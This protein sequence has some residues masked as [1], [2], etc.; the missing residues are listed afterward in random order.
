MD[1]GLLLLEICMVGFCAIL[2][3]LGKRD[4]N[5][6][7]AQQRAATIN[8]SKQLEAT[9]LGLI[10]VLE[11]KSQQIEARIQKRYEELTALEQKVN[12][13]LT[14]SRGSVPEV[15]ASSAQLDMNPLPVRNGFG[16]NWRTRG[17]TGSGDEMSPIS[18]AV[19]LVD[20]GANL[21]TAARIVGM[22][23]LEVETAI[24]ARLLRRNRTAFENGLQ[25][26]TIST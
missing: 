3:F 9:I 7:A 23:S 11:E 21:Q 1:I 8:E 13:S 18:R 5:A 24:K 6:T 22:S 17:R 14:M 2:V 12:G 4:L 16:D 20:G 19:A 25:E 26:S 10:D 15:Q